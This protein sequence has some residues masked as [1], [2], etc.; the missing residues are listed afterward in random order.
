MPTDTPTAGLYKI[1]NNVYEQ[2]ELFT[3]GIELRVGGMD[4][5]C[6]VLITVQY[7]LDSIFD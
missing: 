7:K 4:A 1:I 2:H 5:F 3:A 6:N